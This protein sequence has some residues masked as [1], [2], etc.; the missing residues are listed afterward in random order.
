MIRRWQTILI[1]LKSVLWVGTLTCVAQSTTLDEPLSNSSKLAIKNSVVT[2]STIDTAD[3]RLSA[4]KIFEE[5][6]FAIVE[7][8]PN[9][10]FEV[11]SRDA[12]NASAFGLSALLVEPTTLVESSLVESSL[13][14]QLA[15]EVP[16][17]VPVTTVLQPTTLAQVPLPPDVSLPEDLP[18][19]DEFEAP[20]QDVP[21]IPEDPVPEPEPL[22]TL[23]SPEELLGPDGVSPPDGTDI[24]FGEETFTVSQFEVIGSTVFSE[25]E[26]AEITQPFTNR[27]LTFTQ[28]LE[29]RSA[30]TQ[31]YVEQGYITS[32]AFVPPQTFD[33]GGVGVIRVI[34]GGLEAIQIRGT[35]RLN[36]GYISSRIGV[37]TAPPLNID[38]LLER[39]QVLQLDPLIETISADLQSGTQPGSDLLVVAVTEAETF[40]A[41]YTFDNN[42]SPSVGTARHQLRLTE[43]NLTGLGDRLSLGYNITQGSDGGDIEYT[44]PIN[45]YNGT[46]S[47]FASFSN[48]AVIEDPFDVLDIDSDSDLYEITLRQPLVETPNQEFALGLTA[49]HQRSQT[50]LGFDDIGPFPLSPGADEDGRVKVSAVRFFQEWTR[51]DS[52]QVIALRSQFNIGLDILDATVNDS[53]PD[54]RFFSWQGQG[55]WVRSLGRDSLLLVRGG[56]QLS[57]DS[58]LTLEQF[59]IGGQSTVRGYRQDQLLTDNGI[60]GSVEARFPILR[61]PTNDLLLQIAPFVDV[62]YGWNHDGDNPDPST[63]VGIGT[64]LILTINEDLTARFDWGIPL[65]SVDSDRNT[66]QENGLYFSVGISFF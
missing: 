53:G 31:L 25:A 57:T 41:N 36:P 32:G 42:R 28:L 62:G 24:P 15:D 61:E 45:P 44:V 46:L 34:E 39:L 35:R 47:L 54:S 59:G 23:P 3:V 2:T 21:R 12:I 17:A 65:I 4:N 16:V 30:I 52:T 37:G 14:A 64:G 38:R 55:Q 66:A 19:D 27:P 63:L 56:V 40:D 29:V 58:L 50:F 33:D 5:S 22:P 11:K 18:E 26:L 10:A 7:K 13:L 1:G 43:N 20:L 48:S 8:S 49:S 60:L 6:D 51:R 9:T